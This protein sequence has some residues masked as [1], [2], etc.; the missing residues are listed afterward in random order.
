MTLR[1]T[2]PGEEFL[3]DTIFA[4]GYTLNLFKN[5]VESGLT[6]AQKEALLVASFTVAT[7]TGYAAINLTGG[8]WVTTQGAPSTA[9]YAQQTFTCSG[10]GVAQTIYGYY[11]T[12]T[13]GG[14]LVW[15][16]YLNDA[17]SSASVSSVGDAIRV[18]PSFTLKD[19][20]D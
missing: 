5:D 18:T 20:V 12:R 3:L 6:T 7:F 11:V 10:A 19:T 4:I 17:H 9:T 14:A 13:T 16:E 2:D 15:Y 1:V 8:S